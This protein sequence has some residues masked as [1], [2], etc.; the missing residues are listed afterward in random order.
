MSTSDVGRL[1]NDLRAAGRD[2]AYPPTPQ[3][4]AR[5]IARLNRPSASRRL[6]GR[7]TWAVVTVL[8]LLSALMLVPPARAAILDFI[9]IGVVRILRGPGSPPAPVPVSTSTA[10]Q[11]FQ[12][13][14]TATPVFQTPLT[15]TPAP[16]TI[17][18]LLDLAGETTLSEAQAKVKFPILLP[19]Y[20]SD[21]G[22]PD[23]VYLQDLGGPMLLLVWLD[24]D[25]ADQV[26]MSL[27]EI[28]AGSWAI[29]KFNPPVIQEVKVNGQRAVWTE[30]PYMLETQNRN[31]E[32]KHLVEGHVLIWTQGEITYRLETDL[33]LSQAVRIAESL[34]N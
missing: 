23:K 27:H 22:R 2:F 20:P 31:Y 6:S 21:L 29:T 12:S 32:E 14:L 25:H 1:E 33:S 16:S 15:A 19:T 11:A 17:P 3:L 5:V 34:S 30:G 4:A 8:V 24:H 13:P 10:A 7:W 26:R 9:Q 28:A 18:S